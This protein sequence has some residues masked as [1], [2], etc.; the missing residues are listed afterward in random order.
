[1]KEF[2]FEFSYLDTKSEIELDEGGYGPD[3][4]ITLRIARPKNALWRAFLR[5]AIMSMSFIRIARPIYF[6][7]VDMPFK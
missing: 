5:Q 6:F 7:C 2:D 4:A 1:M 3:L